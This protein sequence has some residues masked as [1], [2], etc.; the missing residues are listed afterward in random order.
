MVVAMIASYIMSLCLTANAVQLPKPD[1]G[2]GFFYSPG[3]CQYA[4][5]TLYLYDMKAH[6][7][8][9]FAPQANDLPGSPPTPADENIARQLNTAA[10][11]GL[12]D[13][14][15]PV[16]CYSVGPQDLIDAQKHKRSD[17]EW[18][19]L[20]VQSIDEPNYGQV[21]YLEEYRDA[22]HKLGV[23]IGTA[24]A[25]YGL[26]GYTQELPWCQ[27]EDVGKKVPGYAEFL[28][29]WIVLVG[30]LS[31]AVQELAVERRAVVGGYLAYP[32]SD[33]LDRWTFGLWAWKARTKIN[34]LWAYIDKTPGWD[35]SRITET[36]EG[37]VYTEHHGGYAEGI[38]DYRV[39][40]AVEDLGTSACE[41]WL[42]DLRE[43]ITLGW[44]PRA[45]VKDN[46]HLEVPTIDMDKVRAEG[47][48]LLEA[49]CD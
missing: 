49:R 33:L 41:E 19:E 37:P 2:F 12:T 1:V 48:A 13:T 36:P 38:T 7:C 9:T 31:S 22:A 35:Y 30:T 27:P 43:Q 44:W 21:R 25:G 29:I 42:R 28:D 6:G 47:L 18:P 23:R 34:L 40:Q 10:L 20:V 5:E 39:L 45:Y 32:A 3:R 8:N 17:V 4:N 11:V 14:R 26:T 15:F 16:I 24:C 46:Q